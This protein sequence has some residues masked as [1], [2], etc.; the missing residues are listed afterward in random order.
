MQRLNNDM[1][2]SIAEEVMQHVDI[3]E[4]QVFGKS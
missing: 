2:N 1:S 4:W 3:K